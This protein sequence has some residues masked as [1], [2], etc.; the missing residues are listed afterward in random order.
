MTKPDGKNAAGEKKKK[1]VLLVVAYDGTGYSGFAAQKNPEIRTIEGELNRALSEL[2]GTGV[3]VTGASR[4]DAGVHALCNY[5]VFDTD[6]PIPPEKFAAAVNSRLP[7]DI[8]VRRS[9]EVDPDFHPRNWNTEKTYEYRIYCAQI[10]D[11]LRSRYFC[12]TYAE[13]DVEKMRRA[14]AYLVGEH[15]FASFANP[16][17]STLTT[18]REITS[19]EIEEHPCAVPDIMEEMEDGLPGQENALPCEGEKALYQKA[20]TADREIILRV[21]GRG[22]L[23]NMVRIIA[24]TLIRVG[25]GMTDP[26]SMPEILERRNRQAAGDTAPAC[27]LCLV[28]YRILGKKKEKQL[29]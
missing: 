22:F 19:I 21:S 16:A 10:P 7:D 20:K 2:T 3:L 9:C 5:A 4:T 12:W 28:N 24:G 17:G 15:D 8:R 29:T 6:S 25:R 27:G 13:L 11:P 1:R 18:V 23:Y 14:A 26:D